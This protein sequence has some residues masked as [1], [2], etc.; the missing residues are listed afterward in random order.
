[1]VCFDLVGSCTGL[2]VW[3]LGVLFGLRVCWFGVWVYGGFC[4]LRLL[5]LV[6]VGLR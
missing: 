4:F 5:R 6:T 3:D 2:L 1:M